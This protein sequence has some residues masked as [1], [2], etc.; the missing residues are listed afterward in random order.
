LCTALYGNSSYHN[1]NS[2]QYSKATGNIPTP[3][4][5]TRKFWEWRNIMIFSLHILDMFG[6]GFFHNVDPLAQDGLSRKK[7]KEK[8]IDDQT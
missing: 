2:K 8:Y 5:A 6:K 3:L 7:R 1:L 4:Q